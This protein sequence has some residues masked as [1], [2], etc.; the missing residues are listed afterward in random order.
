MTKMKNTKLRVWDYNKKEMRIF[1]IKIQRMG[2][3]NELILC[4]AFGYD[5]GNATILNDPINF[6][7][8]MHSTG[9]NDIKENLV[10]EAD[11]VKGNDFLGIVEYN[12]YGWQVRRFDADGEVEEYFLLSDYEFEVVSN[13][14]KNPNFR[15]L[16]EED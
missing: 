14:Y 8:I 11:I 10:F 13:K 5:G 1:D 2:Y 9:F 12:N 7:E 6:S 15:D 4:K 16:L 3:H